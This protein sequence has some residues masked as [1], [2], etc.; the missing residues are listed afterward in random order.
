MDSQSLHMESR[1][2]LEH[3]FCIFLVVRAPSL[4]G[5]L[6]NLAERPLPPGILEFL[7]LSED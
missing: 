7:N 5:F 2:D 4:I 1:K 3:T 6:K